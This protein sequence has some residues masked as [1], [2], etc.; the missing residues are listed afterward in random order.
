MENKTVK[1]FLPHNFKT[2]L[3]LL[4]EPLRPA[5]FIVPNIYADMLAIAQQTEEDEIGWLGTVKELGDERYLIDSIHM[6]KMQVGPG[7]QLFTEDGLGEYFTE[8][9]L[10][11]IDACN[12]MLFWGHVHSGNG[13]S[14]SPQDEDQM[15]WFDHNDYFIRGIFGRKGRAEF[16]LFDYKKGIRWNDIPWMI[17]IPEINNPVSKG[18]EE[19]WAK[20]VETKVEKLPIPEEIEEG[21]WQQYFQSADFVPNQKGRQKNGGHCV[22]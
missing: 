8:L 9:A 17:Y 20:E 6:A 3:F 19:K 1:P 15:K 7:T 5:I 16:T 11:D 13:T 10:N 22:S 18:T 12:R 14:P 4:A 21:E 2:E